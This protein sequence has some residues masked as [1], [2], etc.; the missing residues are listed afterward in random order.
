MS[1]VLIALASGLS[2]TS[3]LAQTGVSDDRVSLPDGPG[4]LEGIGDNASVNPNMGSM[5]YS[6]DIALPQGFAGATPS[7]GLSYS[8]SAGSS[9]VGIGWMM[10]LPFIE[11][12][13]SR[14]LPEYSRDDLFVAD[15][16]EQLVLSVPDDTNPIY[17]ARYE[18]GFVRYSW[19]GA[20]DG[21]DGSWKAERPDGSVAYYGATSEG[22][23]VDSARFFAPG[24]TFRYLLTSTV[25][26]YGHEVRYT[27]T[28]QGVVPLISRIEYLFDA[29]GQARHVV[30]FDYED[31]EDR[32][33]DARSG[34]NELLN[35]RLTGIRVTTGGAQV[36]R[37]ALDYEAYEA[38]GGFSRL[39]GV[40]TFGALDGLYPIEPRFEYSQPLGA[41]CEDDACGQ[42]YIVEMGNVASGVAT[43]K[44]SLI[45]INGDALPDLIDA[46]RDNAPHTFYLNRLGADGANSFAAAATESSVG[47]SGAFP[48]GTPHVQMLDFNGDGLSDMLNAQTRQVLINRAALNAAGNPDWLAVDAMAAGGAGLPNFANETIRFIDYDGD[49]RIDLITSTSNPATTNIYRNDGDGGFALAT[50]VDA[51]GWGFDEDRLELEDMNGDGLTDAVIKRANEIR[52]RINLGRG[53]FTAELAVENVILPAEDLEFADLE[54]INGDSLTDLVT[55]VGGE[56]RYQ[57]N[58]NGR[59]FDPPATVGM[60][61]NGMVPNRA[62]DTAIIYADMNGNGSDDVVFITQQGRVSYVEV[63]PVR[64]NL[65]TRVTNGIGM[66]TMVEYGTSV[67]EQARDGGA[68]SAS[69]P[70][71]LPSSMQVVKTIDTYA[72]QAVAGDVEHDLEVYT[73]ATGF[74]DGAEKQFR[75]YARVEELNEGDDTQQTSLQLLEY[76]VGADDPYRFGREL[77]TTILGGQAEG[78]PL[79]FVT[80]ESDYEDCEVAELERV[81]PLFPVRSICLTENR[82]VLQEQASEAEW[83]TITTRTTYDGY[84]NSTLESRLGVQDVDGDELYTEAEFIAPGAA[85]GD[86]WITQRVKRLVTYGDP[87]TKSTLY[88]ETLNFFDEGEEPF[89]G[90]ASG[91]LSRGTVTR[92]QDRVADGQFVESMRRS[93]NADGQ[94]VEVIDPNGSPGETTSHRQRLTWD[95][96]LMVA[97]AALLQDAAGEYTLESR[98]TYDP[99]FLKPSTASDNAVFVGGARVTPEVGT[100]YTYDEFGRMST[101]TRTPGDASAPDQAF[102]FALASPMSRI[103]TQGRSVKGGDVDRVAHLCLDGLGRGVQSRTRLGDGS[104][105]VDG[106]RVLN[107]KGQAVRAFVA[108]A[109]ASD[110]CETSASLVPQGTPV[111][112]ARFDALDRGVEVTNEDGTTSRAEYAPLLRRTFAEDDTDTSSPNFKTPLV[113]R[114]DGLQRTLAYE[115]A[116]STGDGS[117]VALAYD[118][119][120]QLVEVMDAAGHRHTQD[121][122]ALG[123]VTRT[124]NPNAGETTFKYDV[125][126]NITERTTAATTIRLAYDGLNRVVAE[127]DAADED[128]TRT[129]TSYDRLPD[130]EACTYGAGREVERRFP[131]GAEATT[132]AVGVDRTGFDD[133]GNLVFRSRRLDGRDFESRFVFD[134]TNSLVEHTYPDGATETRTYDAL[135]RVTSIP[136]FVDAVAFDG[137]GSRTSMTR[138]N[139]VVDTV[140]YDARLRPTSLRSTV[141]AVVL[142]GTDLEY[143]V[144]GAL[145]AITDRGAE[146]AGRPQQ[147]LSL[148]SDAWHRTTQVAYGAEDAETLSFAFDD[149][150]NVMEINS[151]AG[152]TSPAHVG[153][154]TYDAARPNAVVTAGEQTLAYDAVGR[155]V[156]RGDATFE[157][158]WRGPISRVV[159][160]GAPDEVSVY[161]SQ[162]DRVMKLS[163]GG[164]T[165]YVE[166]GFEVRDGVSV[167][168]TMLSDRV[169][170][171][172][173]DA[174]AAKVLSDLAP[175]TA[176]GDALS[177]VGD[178]HID[179]GDAWLAQAAEAGVVT[180]SGG[181]A[182]S[183]VARLLRA[184]AR[185]LLLDD[186]SPVVHLH[187]DQLG[188]F[189]L[190]TD[191]AGAPVGEQSFYTTG[192]VRAATGFVDTYGFTGQEQDSGSGLL[193][194]AARNLDPRTGRWD[195]PDPSFAVL[196]EGSVQRLGES[197]SGYAYV[198]NQPFDQVDPTGLAGEKPTLKQ[199]FSAWKA[200]RVTPRTW[201]KQKQANKAYA[202]TAKTAAARRARVEAASLEDVMSNPDDMDNLLA[203][204]QTESSGENVEFLK[205][206]GEI[207]N[208]LT[209]PLAGDSPVA[210]AL[211]E[212][213]IAIRVRNLTKNY[214]KDTGAKQV[215]LPNGA[216]LEGTQTGTLTALSEAEGMTNPI[217]RAQASREALRGAEK[218]IRAFVTTNTLS[219]YKAAV[220]AGTF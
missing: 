206:I 148:V 156:A 91:T 135:G 157:R 152:G 83:K 218:R 89:T 33:S 11:R 168:Y 29:A 111:V 182:P 37:Y 125:G 208:L 139:G 167:R 220:A 79:P 114:E 197:T 39:A 164:V 7:L 66:V 74:Y 63:F 110:A 102:S 43:G 17:R 64:P 144:D 44:A 119:L 1:G 76:E 122:D 170:R 204:A 70:H 112:S 57:L 184:S 52:Y 189:V 141:G 94:T 2:P 28:N 193:H 30:T 174:L 18:G 73:Y 185:R 95:L 186:T 146:R 51:I 26:V 8:S 153:T 151:S 106:Y 210:R 179:A 67:A 136:G 92:S 16:S 20:G 126:S 99:I 130:C 145:T 50:G 115:R 194:F 199:R 217:A 107:R 137:R 121:F 77:R 162:I 72:D 15:G 209:G 198:G 38:A 183:G 4:S 56:I 105:Q 201:W 219:R 14:G 150:D 10:G 19:L 117:V 169:A 5:A 190:A 181:P 140:A 104:F 98:Y 46:S 165:Y 192:Q 75:G 23:S 71:P 42:P 211:Q 205:I 97:R 214:I 128:R 62:A 49:R 123:R 13:T 48:L 175:A 160:E 188:S 68:G 143:A 34:S 138:A 32:I 116:L 124:V 216:N 196:D 69:W 155:L 133:R 103:S 187:A 84:G 87:A 177:P 100:A 85:T 9:V 127:W 93:V 101:K 147:G 159:R 3:A 154:L 12:M 120:G 36:R 172:S 88:R 47:M 27:Y 212:G 161:A 166:P 173:G 158:D 82:E 129:T 180:L 21:A 149:L 142:L 176:E 203:F 191:E 178:G 108:Y 90:M 207:D 86:R 213:K 54:D 31:R 22:R 113:V 58:R 215:N 195:E 132:D 6:V 81:D 202:K 53:R 45:D 118:D 40:K 78:A 59:R 200:A 65:L 80:R 55:V 131:L 96:N 35:S 60:L 61:K 109:S 163:D 41:E 25:D 24:G 134:N 171:T